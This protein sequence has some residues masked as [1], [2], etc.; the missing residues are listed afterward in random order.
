MEIRFARVSGKQWGGN[1]AWLHPDDAKEE[2]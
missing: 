2:T 1:Y